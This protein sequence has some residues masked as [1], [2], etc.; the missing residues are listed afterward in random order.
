M[1]HRGHPIGH[2]DLLCVGGPAE[3]LHRRSHIL[4]AV[5]RPPDL[6]LPFRLGPAEALRQRFVVD[7]ARNLLGSAFRRPLL[8]IAS[9]PP[10]PALR[11]LD[12][13]LRGVEQVAWI[14]PEKPAFTSAGR[15]PQ[16][17][18]CAW[19]RIAASRVS[20]SKAKGIRLRSTSSGEPW[21]MP[22][23]TRTRRLPTVTR[24][25]EPVTKPAAPRNWMLMLTGP[26]HG[27]GRG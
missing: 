6:G 23:S 17:S 3:E 12:L 15:R 1:E 16:W 27:R 8:R 13:E 2:R 19:V 26:P 14:G 18:R 7:L 21:N 5:Q 25:W 24:N 22:Q 11:E 4:L 10:V 20:G 9:P